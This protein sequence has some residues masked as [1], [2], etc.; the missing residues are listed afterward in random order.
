M[1]G[2]CPASGSVPQ[3]QGCESGE[4]DRAGSGEDVGE[5]AGLTA[6]AGLAPAPGSSGEVA[7]LAFDDRV[8]G[9]VGL[10]PGGSR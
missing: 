9:A 8:V 7:D 2:D 1:S 4:V 10:L 6:A 3:A 5:D